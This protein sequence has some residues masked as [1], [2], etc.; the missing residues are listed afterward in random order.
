MHDVPGSEEAPAH[1]VESGHG[2]VVSR[3]IVQR[4]KMA[5]EAPAGVAGTD[6][7]TPNASVRER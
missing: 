5:C 2:G 7:V 3:T 4:A 1:V 6:V